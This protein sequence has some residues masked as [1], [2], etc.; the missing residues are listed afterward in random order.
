[1]EMNKKLPKI[2]MGA[3]AWGDD[4]TF[5]GTHTAEAM[6]PIFNAAMENGLNL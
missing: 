6:K 2:A 3:W 5:G 1:M 4:G